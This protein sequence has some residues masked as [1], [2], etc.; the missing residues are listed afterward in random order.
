MNTTPLRAILRTCTTAATTTFLALLTLAPVSATVISFPMSIEFSGATAPVGSAPWLTATF[1]DQNT[2]GSVILTLATTNLTGTEFV[3]EFDFNLRTTY[4]PATALVFSAPTKVGTFTSPTISTLINGFKADGDGKYDVK[5][6]FATGGGASGRFGVGESVQYTITGAGPAAGTLVAADF[7]FL[8][9]PDG[10]HG[11][12]YV[13]AHI[14]SIGA[15]G[16]DSGW[17]THEPGFDPF[18]EIPEPNSLVLLAL[19]LCGLAQRRSF[20]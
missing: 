1:D 2:P 13:A 4:D 11:P 18:G 14:Q 5:L 9:H 8:S 15:N 20:R 6:G 17:I 12:F 10:G 3:R 19:S 7:A 16:D